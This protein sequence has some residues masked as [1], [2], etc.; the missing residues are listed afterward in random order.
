M[1]TLLINIE[2]KDKAEALRKFL[3]ELNF[4]SKVKTVT[5]KDA[6]IEALEE[7]EQ[8][9]KSILKRKNKAISKYL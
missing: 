4:V 2:N 5:K 7:H 9:K 6:L 3:S 8:M 1:E